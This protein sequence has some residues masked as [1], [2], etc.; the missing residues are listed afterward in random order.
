MPVHG[1]ASRPAR[2]R[3][4]GEWEARCMR[5]SAR[6]R[7]GQREGGERAAALRHVGVGGAGMGRTRRGGGEGRPRACGGIARAKRWPLPCAPLSTSPSRRPCH[8][9]PA[10]Q[11]GC[12][13]NSAAFP[14]NTIPKK[15]ALSVGGVSE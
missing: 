7:P 4:Q 11:A 13:T 1:E 6:A 9:A 2:Q 8:L 10:G 12:P 15:I 3:E 14:P 5:W